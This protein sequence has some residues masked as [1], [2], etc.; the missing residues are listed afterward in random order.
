MAKLLA[1]APQATFDAAQL[2]IRVGPESQ[3]SK[4]RLG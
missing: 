2:V 4:S 1:V 3:S